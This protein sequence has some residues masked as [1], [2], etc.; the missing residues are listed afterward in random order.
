MLVR[1]KNEDN[2][3]P[4]IL[5]NRKFAFRL[6]YGNFKPDSPG[7]TTDGSIHYRNH[8]LNRS[9]F[10]DGLDHVLLREIQPCK[11]LCQRTELQVMGNIT[12]DVQCFRF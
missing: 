3:P 1:K 8:R 6:Y 4:G 11:I 10:N 5:V 2:D 12:I 7:Q 9:I